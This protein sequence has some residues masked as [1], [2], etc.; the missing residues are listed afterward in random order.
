MGDGLAR[1]IV[2]TAVTS[3][4]QT[5]SVVIITPERNNVLNIVLKEGE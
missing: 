4:F 1:H 5:D 3:L 2:G